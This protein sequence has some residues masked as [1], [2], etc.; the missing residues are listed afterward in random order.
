MVTSLMPGATG[1]VSRTAASAY[2][3]ART[4]RYASAPAAPSGH[5]VRTGHD[6]IAYATDALGTRSPSRRRRPAPGAPPDAAFAD[7]PPHRGDARA[8]P[9]DRRE[10]T[11]R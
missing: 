2:V 4:D 8:G 11:D 1:V 10:S 6:R 3:H 5:G 7:P 9:A